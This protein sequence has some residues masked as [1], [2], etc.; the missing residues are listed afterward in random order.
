MENAEGVWV[1][2]LGPFMWGRVDAEDEGWTHKG[3]L[4]RFFR[5]GFHHTGVHLY[6]QRACYALYWTRKK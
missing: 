3:K 1:R 6:T 2:K 4:I 5:V